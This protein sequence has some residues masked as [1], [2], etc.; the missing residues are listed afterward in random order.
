[1]VYL[2]FAL[3]ALLAGG[4]AV[5]IRFINREVPPLWGTALRFVIA[6][7]LVT[8]LF[9]GFKLAL[10]RG[11]ALRGAVVFGVLQFA[12]AFGLYSFALVRI[13]AGL[14]QTILALVP[15]VTLLLARGQE[16][17]RRAPLIGALIGVIGVGTV[18]VGPL[19]S[20][21]PVTSLLAVLG[22][23]F[24]FAQA[25][26]LVRRF[27]PV[28][29]IAFNAVGIVVATP[30][31]IGASFAARETW[32][33]PQRSETWIAL[34]YLAG[35]GSIVVFLLHVFVLQSWSASRTAFVMVL[36]P[37]VTVVLSAWLDQEPV[38][39]AL[40]LGGL[41]V[42]LGVYVGALRGAWRGER[43]EADL[44]AGQ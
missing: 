32:L 21:V 40:L 35:I 22:S 39:L 7:V 20:G 33:V 41:L 2:A 12:G 43:V 34:A 37:F 36:I 6:A 9:V 25:L 29:P 31:L 3:E 42:L 4:N 23:V 10:P 8:M 13:K 15:L 19:Q 16:R 30:L 17:L 44:A 11:R 1:V 27:P 18:S 38:T 14:G 28:H 24:C 5:A 26:L